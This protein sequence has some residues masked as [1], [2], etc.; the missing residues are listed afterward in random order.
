MPKKHI[1]PDGEDAE[2]PPRLTLP[3]GKWEKD[4]VDG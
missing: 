3:D 1:R 4:I 2:R